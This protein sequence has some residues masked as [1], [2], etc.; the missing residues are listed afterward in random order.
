MVFVDAKF[1]STCV[2]KESSNHIMFIGS[3]CCCWVDIVSVSLNVFDFV[4]LCN[5][6]QNRSWGRN[7]NQQEPHFQYRLRASDF[8]NAFVHQQ[9]SKLPSDTIIIKPDI[10]TM[11]VDI[12]DFQQEFD[13]IESAD[14][15]LRILDD[16]HDRSPLINNCIFSTLALSID[17]L[18]FDVCTSACQRSFRSFDCERD[19][20]TLSHAT[21]KSPRAILLCNP[22]IQP[23]GGRVLCWF[24]EIHYFV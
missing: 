14:T 2:T 1:D 9:K 21:P 24:V 15:V 7:P 20:R 18:C 3:S 16:G 4:L 17:P 11:M 19:M 22:L 8:N 10:S 5:K 13:I 23:R 12:V 6:K